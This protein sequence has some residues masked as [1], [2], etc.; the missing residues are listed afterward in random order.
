MGIV[1]AAKERSELLAELSNSDGYAVFDRRGRPIGLFIGVV[2]PTELAIRHDGTFFWR[3]RTVALEAVESVVPR[4]RAIVLGIDRAELTHGEKD[5][6]VAAQ[7]P[8]A[9][10][11]PPSEWEDRLRPYLSSES[12]AA[13]AESVR[14][15]GEPAAAQPEG[16]GEHLLF[17]G[18]SN[19]YEIIVR[20]GGPPQ[21]LDVILL[22]DDAPFRVT[23]VAGSPLPDDARR[24]AYVVK[25]E[26][27]QSR[28]HPD[29]ESSR[30]VP[31]DVRENGG[32]DMSAVQPTPAAD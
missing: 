11:T 8:A 1:A 23:K 12:E 5:K 31:G 21:P 30:A 19:G 2:S 3:R 27:A 16:E 4:A 9:D 17:I 20:P 7:G 32:D 10:P 25:E 14:D 24:C 22:G 26:A 6:D 13:A 29:D 28:L 15:D 18:T